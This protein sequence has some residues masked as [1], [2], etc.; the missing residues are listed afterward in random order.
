MKDDK[1]A[2]AEG[3]TIENALRYIAAI[4]EAVRNGIMDLP[5][6]DRFFFGALISS[7]LLVESKRIQNHIWSLL[8]TGQA[9]KMTQEQDDLLHQLEGI[10]K[11][12]DVTLN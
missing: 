12:K 3:V 5:L 7:T 6:E 1:F 8:H 10:A 9:I 11:M 4:G 2:P